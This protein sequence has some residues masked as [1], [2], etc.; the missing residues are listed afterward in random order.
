[1]EGA[2]PLAPVLDRRHRRFAE[3]EYLR[4]AAMLLVIVMHAPLLCVPYPPG[5]LQ[6]V[7]DWIHP[8]VGVDLFFVISGYL[9]GRSFVGPFEAGEP[10]DPVPPIAAFWVRRFYRLLPACAVWIG[11]TLACC[12]VFD[13]SPLWI[14]PHA[15]YFKALASLLAVRNFEESY[16]QTHFGYVWS[17]S[18]ENQF[19][20]LLPIVLVVVRRRWRVPGMVALCALNAVWR[21]GGETW[22]LFRYDGLLYGLLLFELERAGHAETLARCLPHSRGGRVALVA[23]AGA[24]MLTSPLVLIYLHPLAW[25][26]VNCAAFVLV[27]AA[28]SG[29]GAIPM[30]RVLS[31]VFLWLGA[32]SYSLY[33]C[34]IPVWTLVIELMQRSHLGG[35][36]LLAL[37]FALA[38]AA[39]LF[40]AD[41]SYL[42]VE[43][44]LQERGRIR[45]R[46]IRSGT[47]AARV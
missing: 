47:D 36:H 6:R 20:V 25:S 26:L 3:I 22:W 19:Y 39:S 37:R 14:P 45:A 5:A 32:R 10:G 1:M 41:L 38:I 29:Q 44:P 4:A 43:L 12:I 42:R 24:A 16:A 17:L 46:A 9:I 23:C 35:R 8:A 40:L 21:P 27:L 15:M 13:G 34:H 2:L 33:L 28:R 7:Q 18:V 31:T 11:F 30:P